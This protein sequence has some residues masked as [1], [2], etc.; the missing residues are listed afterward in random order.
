MVDQIAQALAAAHAHGIVHLDLKPDNV[1]LISTD[2]RDDFVKVIDF[3]IARAV[4]RA[5]LINEPVIT[6]TPEYMAPEQAAGTTEEIDHRADQFA[7]AAVSYRLL[8]GHQPFTGVDAAALIHQ[9]LNETP[10]P[11]S[12]WTPALGAE[13]D[14]VIARG[15]SKRPA[16]R[17]PDVMGFADALRDALD[18]IAIDRRHR[19][20]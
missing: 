13:V 14:A 11:P 19:A 12:Q 8:T 15:M 20:R 16:D 10:R 7:L 5:R 1:I 4:W 6:G 9:V 3:G 18:V 17:Y 2:G